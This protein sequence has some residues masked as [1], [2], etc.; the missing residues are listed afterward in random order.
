MKSLHQFASVKDYYLEF[1]KLSIQTD[2]MTDATRLG[3]FLDN[4]KPEL[5]SYCY[6]N[7][8]KTLEQAYDFA[9]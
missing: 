5:T 8:A 2:D 9:L 4:L 1:M 7:Q 3:L 6:L